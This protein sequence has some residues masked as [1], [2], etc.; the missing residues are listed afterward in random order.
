MPIGIETI[1][2]GKCEGTGGE[3]DVTDDVTAKNYVGMKVGIRRG[4]GEELRRGIVRRRMFDEEGQ[5]IGAATRNPLADTRRYEVE[6][7]DDSTETLS[8]NL[9]SENILAQVAKHG[10]KHRLMEEKGDITSP[11]M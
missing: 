7:E 4:D 9:L 11:K 5:P 10:H 1:D 3:T 8:A 6:Y 2:K